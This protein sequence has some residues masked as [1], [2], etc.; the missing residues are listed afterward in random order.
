VKEF[1]RGHWA[2]ECLKGAQYF[3][4]LLKP[5]TSATCFLGQDPLFEQLMQHVL[6][7]SFS[8]Q[9]SCRQLWQRSLA[10]ANGCLKEKNIPLES[11]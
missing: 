1:G 9:L 11:V 3:E 4:S 10:I 8:C 2:L 7:W 5:K 6:D